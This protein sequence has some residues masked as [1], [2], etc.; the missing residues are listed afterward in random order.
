M[1]EVEAPAVSA[2]GDE[3]TAAIT[4]CCVDLLSGNGH[5]NYCNSRTRNDNTTIYNGCNSTIHCSCDRNRDRIGRSGNSSD[6]N[7]LIVILGG[8]LALPPQRA[9]HKICQMGLLGWLDNN[10]IINW[11]PAD[12]QVKR[13]SS[14]THVDSTSTV[15]TKMDPAQDPPLLLGEQ[16]SWKRE[17]AALNILFFVNLINYMDRVTI[18]AVLSKVKNQYGL[19]DK[20]SG[21]L[22][23]AFVISYMI[24]APVF[25]YLGDRYSRKVLMAGGVIFWSITTLLGSLPPENFFLFLAL[26]GLVGIGE[27]SYSTIAPTIIGDM[28]PEDKRTIALGIFYYAIPIGSGLGYMVGSYIAIWS[29]KWYWALR[30]TPILGT[31]ATLLIL[32]V[33]REPPRGEADGGVHISTTSII[34]D[35]KDLAGNMSYIWSTLGF[36]A[37]TFAL[38]AMSWWAPDFIER[39]ERIR[40]DDVDLGRIS[41]I[42]GTI[43]CVGGATGITLAV[44]LSKALRER[45]NRIDPVICAAGLICGVPLIMSAVLLENTAPLATWFLFFIGLTL[46]SLNWSVVPD[47]LLYTVLPTR[48]GTASAIQILISHMFGDAASPYIVGAISDARS[49]DMTNHEEYFIALR[50]AMLL[51]CVILA[52]GGCVFIF[53][54]FTILRDKKRCQRQLQGY[55]PP[56]EGVDTSGS[57]DSENSTPA[58][59]H[60]GGGQSQY[61]SLIDN[62]H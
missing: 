35:V 9:P 48:R 16:R 32:F 55:V 36:T 38:G 26:R 28:F 22:Q 30:I 14:V 59:G 7:H 56:G 54:I 40:T 37:A 8:Y 57:D 15:V 46:L 43:T 62:Q 2:G 52:V 10:I 17:W 3:V 34:E 6:S 27:A 4:T 50:N 42:F 61:G 18:A 21:F 13:V 20:K 33:L 49:T 11:T 58:L 53:N 39:A 60:R 45:F 12:N 1:D 29:G 51:P 44:Y 47:M 31:T 5:K 19:D 25:G 23:T 41:F 24:F